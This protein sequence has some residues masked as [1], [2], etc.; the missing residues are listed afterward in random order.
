MT[1]RTYLISV[2]LLLSTAALNAQTTFGTIAGVVRDP[3]KA[4]IGGATITA[5]KLDGNAIRT[6]ISGSDGIYAFSDVVPGNY[7]ITAQTEGFGDITVASVQ[8]VA[9]RAARTDISVT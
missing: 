6:T 4:P 9:G 8:V 7:S 5:T 2:A 3:G 1:K